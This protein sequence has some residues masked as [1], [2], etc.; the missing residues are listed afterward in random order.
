MGAGDQKFRII[1]G[2][3]S[4]KLAW[5]TR[6]PALKHMHA[7]TCIL[8]GDFLLTLLLVAPMQVSV[9]MAEAT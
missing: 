7:C 9:V 1:V 3:I 2:C 5:D 8:S 6:D 4:S